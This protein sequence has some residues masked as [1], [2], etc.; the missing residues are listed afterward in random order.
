MRR[1][2]IREKL[3]APP[4]DEVLAWWTS[5]YQRM[6]LRQWN[7]ELADVAKENADTD[8]PVRVSALDRVFASLA[9]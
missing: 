7:S 5:S 2:A 3:A 6:L 8:T 9:D 4:T 1:A